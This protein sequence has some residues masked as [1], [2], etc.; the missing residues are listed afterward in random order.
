MYG[1]RRGVWGGNVFQ[2]MSCPPADSEI[3]IP[4]WKEARGIRPPDT[5]EW[6]DSN[7]SESAGVRA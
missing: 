7:P 2:G 5:L 1:E 4:L 3:E 6:K